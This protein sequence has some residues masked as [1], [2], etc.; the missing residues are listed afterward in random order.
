MDERNEIIA[1]QAE[2]I[3]QLSAS[4]TG[5][6]KILKQVVNMN[7]YVDADDYSDYCWFCRHREGRGH[8]S[9]CVWE[10]AQKALSEYT[11]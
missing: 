4:V 6:K 1:N 9:S 3:T 2:Y 8:S 7:P 5:L 10:N 11:L